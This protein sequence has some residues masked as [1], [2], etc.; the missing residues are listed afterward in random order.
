MLLTTATNE[1]LC[2][3]S[4][5]L[6]TLPRPRMRLMQK[7]SSSLDSSSARTQCRG[8][9]RYRPHPRQKN[10]VTCGRHNRLPRFASCMRVFRYVMQH[11]RVSRFTAC[12]CTSSRGGGSGAHLLLHGLRDVDLVAHAVDAHVGRVG[13]DGQPA[14]AAEPASQHCIMSLEVA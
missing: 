7:V 2:S 3:R 11:H 5:A 6:L 9:C 8:G 14:Q 12:G 1:Q 13:L 10:M 4:A